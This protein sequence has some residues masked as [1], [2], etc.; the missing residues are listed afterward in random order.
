MK[1]PGRRALIEETRKAVHDESTSMER[2]RALDK[3][4]PAGLTN[5]R[6]HGL[7]PEHGKERRGRIRKLKAE[8]IRTVVTDRVTG[9]GGDDVI[10]AEFTEH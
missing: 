3:R 6:F 1:K 9:G 2:F 10:D 8:I 5:D 4:S 7:R